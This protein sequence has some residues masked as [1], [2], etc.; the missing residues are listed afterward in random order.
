MNKKLSRLLEPGMG[1]YFLVLLLFV[2]VAVWVKQYY[3]AGAELLVIL[4]LFVHN[5]VASGRRK[6]ALLHYIQSTTDSLGTAFKTGSPFPMAVIKMSDSEIIWGNASFYQISGLRDSFLHQKMEDVVP[7]FSTRWLTE[8][9]TECP[10]DIELQG[11]RYRVY[12]NLIRSEDEHASLLLATLYLADMTEMFNVR[13][14]Y[15]R[16]RPIVTVI[17]VDNYDELTNN[18]PDSAISS[19]DARINDRI[20]SWCENLG[21]LLRKFERNRY[22]LI[23]ES[24]DLPR[25]QEEKFSILDDIRAITNP[26]GVAATLSIG[27]GKDGSSFQENYAFANLSI[28]MAL[29]RGGD[30]AV[31]KDRYNFNFFG[32]RTKETERRTKVKARVIASSLNELISQSS[33]VFIMGHRMADLDALGAAMGLVCIC[34]K[35]TRPVHIVLDQEKNAAKA[36]LT[37]LQDYPEYDNLFVSGEDALLAADSKTLL[38]VVDT[39]RPDQVESLALL[40]S[41]NRVAVIDHHRR[42]ADYIEQVVLNLHEPFASSASEL[43]TE[44]LQYAVEPKEIRIMEAQALLAGLVLD[45]KNFSVRTGSRTFEAAAFLRRA[46]ADTVDVKKLFQN[47]LDDTIARYQIVQAARLYRNEIAIAALEYQATRTLVAQA[48]DELLNIKGILT[49]FVLY[50]DGDR[51]VI[52]ARSIG[53]ANVQ[54]I[55]EPLGGGGNA[56]TAGAQVPGKSVREVLAELVASIDKFY[57]G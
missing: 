57:E 9:R 53:E 52:S 41:V 35:R 37:V 22:L 12:G 23:F 46:G 3:V 25:L 44:I 7:R 54:V 29:S 43:V 32:G 17:L 49:S 50:Q 1:L 28:E 15:I 56:A 2:G 42:A 39:N 4:L 30:Q 34:R 26:S 5:R 48:A 10:Q 27:I 24:K 31:I 13:D 11:R 20:S 36:L 33:Q 6:K 8:G 45:T 19:L 16:T 51:V 14:E 55:L 47:D 21:G 40:E 18:L 38:I